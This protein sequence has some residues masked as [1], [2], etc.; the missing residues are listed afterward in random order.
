MSTRIL[1]IED[2]PLF[3]DALIVNVTCALPQTV[4]SHAATLRDAREMVAAEPSLV[5]LDL[6]LPDALGFE[7]LIEMRRLCPTAP[8]LVIS[9]Y[10]DESIV[11]RGQALGAA[12]FVSKGETRDAIIDT[13]RRLLAGEIL[14]ERRNGSDKGGTRGRLKALTT[15][16]LRVLQL[17]CQG[18]LN[19]Q[20]AHQLAVS[21]ATIK[22]HVGEILH[23]LGV[24]TRTQAV[25]EMS[26]AGAL[27][28]MAFSQGEPRMPERR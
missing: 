20:I 28:A 27:Q 3:A 22:A 5:L 9:A 12:G 13:V 10:C 19:K 11:E 18:L 15:Q 4:V 2:H 23:K 14:G 24:S 17:V 8:I 7:S 1:I 25:A 6:N 21:E 26:R 16:Q